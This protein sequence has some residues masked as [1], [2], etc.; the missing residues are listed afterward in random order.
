MPRYVDF[1]LNG[2]LNLDDMVSARLKLEDIN[3]AFESVVKGEI[4]RS[5]LIFE[6]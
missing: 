1:Y 4:A 6:S 3:D 5:V 2:K